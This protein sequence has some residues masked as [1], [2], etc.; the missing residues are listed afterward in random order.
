MDYGYIIAL[1]IPFMMIGTTLNSIIRADGSPKYAM[2]SMITG[3][4]LNMILDPIAIFGFH[5][6]IKGA[7]IATVIS[8]MVT[9]AMNI[10]Y[11]QKFKT[12]TI[13]KSSFVLSFKRIKDVAMLGISSFITQMCKQK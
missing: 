9:F 5:M 4:V 12:I 7:A 10:W 3:A 8:Q 13:T 1:G 2:F 11:L 6:G